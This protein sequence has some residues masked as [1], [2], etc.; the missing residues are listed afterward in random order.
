MTNNKNENQPQTGQN[1]A[2]YELI[3]LRRKY[4]ELEEKYFKM[5][6]DTRLMYKDIAELKENRSEPI[7][8]I[9][10]LIFLVFQLGKK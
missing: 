4:A 10:P 2:L 7:S 1:A 5:L 6:E 3:T 8:T 9:S